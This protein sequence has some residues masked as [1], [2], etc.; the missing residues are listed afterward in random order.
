MLREKRS[1]E[2][3]L[4][5]SKEKTEIERVEKAEKERETMINI[6]GFMRVEAD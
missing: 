4:Y 1:G 6:P 5:T 3:N 2:G